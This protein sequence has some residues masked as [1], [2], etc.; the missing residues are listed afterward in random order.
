MINQVIIHVP[1]FS[2]PDALEELSEKGTSKR[3]EGF[4]YGFE[5]AVTEA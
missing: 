5:H 4:F 2:D 3:E 1:P